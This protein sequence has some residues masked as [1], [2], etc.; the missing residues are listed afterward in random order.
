MGRRFQT[1][2]DAL[3]NIKTSNLTFKDKVQVSKNYFLHGRWLEDVELKC[4]NHKASLNSNATFLGAPRHCQELA[5][6]TI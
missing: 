4:K 2:A 1:F 5:L 6:L 3:D